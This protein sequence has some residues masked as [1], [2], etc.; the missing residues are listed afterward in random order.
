[1]NLQREVRKHKVAME[2][3]ILLEVQYDAWRRNRKRTVGMFLTP[4]QVEEI[5]NYD[6]VSEPKT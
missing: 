1:M 6:C 5:M 2:R 3:A 4:A